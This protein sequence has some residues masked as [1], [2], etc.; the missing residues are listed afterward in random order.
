MN[1]KTL[2]VLGTILF[3]LALLACVF[4]GSCRGALA[5]S[6]CLTKGFSGSRVTYAGLGTAFCVRRVGL[7]DEVVPL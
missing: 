4:V 5:E 3:V 7:V 2:G 6:E 1:V